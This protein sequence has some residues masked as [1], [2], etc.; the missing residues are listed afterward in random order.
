MTAVRIGA[1][2]EQGKVTDLSDIC[3]PTDVMA[4]TSLPQVPA[5]YLVSGLP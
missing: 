2:V 1:C 3:P 4:I 5:I